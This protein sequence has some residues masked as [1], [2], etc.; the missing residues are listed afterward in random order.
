MRSRVQV[1][2]ITPAVDAGRYA[3]K[4]IAGDD[5]V[6]GA[7][8][9]RDGHE[10]TAAVVRFRGPGD[11]RWSERPL[12]LDVNDRWYGHFPVDR[13]G[14]WRYQVVAWTDHY[15]SWLDTFRKKFEAGRTGLD[16][17]VLAGI[18]L[19]ERRKVAREDRPAIEALLDLLRDP[20][21]GLAEKL[22]AAADPEVLS[23]LERNPE[24]LDTTVSKPELPLWVDREIAQFSAWYEFFPR[25]EVAEVGRSGTFADAAKRLPAIADMG[26][27]VVYLPPIHPIGHTHRKG[28]NNT[29]VAE[30]GDPGVPWAIGSDEGGHDAVHPDL[31]TIEDFDDFVAQAGRYG[32]EIAL[33]FAIQASPDHP[34]VKE[35]PE[36]FKHRPD[37]SIQYAENPPKEYQDI[38]PVDFDTPDLDGLMT[39][40][41]RIVDH[42]ISHGVKIFR[43]DNPHTKALPF[44]EWLIEGVHRDHPD[45]LFLSEAFTRPKMMKALAKLGFSMSYTYFAWRNSKWELEQYL[46]ELA[47]TDMADYFRPSF[48]TNTPDILTEFL[49][50]GGRPA[51][52]LR[53]LLAGLLSPQYGIY[54]GYEL[55]ENVPLRP[56]SE[57]YLD[58]EK[59][60]YRPRDWERPDSLA[61]YI[62]RLNRI[63]KAHPSLR[64]LR[65]L[66]F[67]HIDDPAM[68]AFSKVARDRTDPMLVIANLDVHSARAAMVHL[69]LWQLGLDR[70]FGPY[71]AHDLMTDTVYVWHG[72]DNYVRL[73]PF[74]EPA[75][76]L[77]L[78]PL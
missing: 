65:S 1:E 46:H 16:I 40:L 24:R 78:R 51:F 53:A 10:K 28:R 77:A 50:T 34:W 66:W 60:Q 42:W 71:E 55:M 23:L 48:W 64:T 58:S 5:V 73:D 62:T 37:G 30:P 63:R 35:H 20:A 75:H 70:H 74:V 4:A 27:D 18:R 76:V 26:F 31:G 11:Q 41:K 36:W 59:Y 44:W 22:A 33:D 13:M 21:I 54:S 67:H 49:Q 12:R 69:D 56:G 61:P 72:A 52:K 9:F 25:S 17:D 14:P 38:Y 45:V 39:E 8:V 57:E 3:A 2:H 15:A 68:M 43:V 29:L 19:L 47:H 6:V 7:D 32:L